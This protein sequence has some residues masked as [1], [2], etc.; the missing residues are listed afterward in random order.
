MRYRTL[1]RTGLEVSEIGLGGAVFA[2]T[3]HGPFDEAN[4]IAAI[5]TALENG[6]NYIDTS[7]H[8]GPSEE[9][10]GR[11]LTGYTGDCII[12]TKIS[13]LQRPTAAETI[14]GVEESLATLRR[15]YV[16]VLLAHDIQHLGEDTDAVEKILHPGG[17]VDGLRQLQREGRVRFIGVSGRLAQ[18]TAAV[19]TGEFDVALSFN[20]FNL[21]DWSAEEALLPQAATHNVGVTMGGVFYQGF[22]SLPLELVLQRVENGLLWTWDWTDTRREFVLN[23][24]EGLREFVGDDLAALRRLAVQFVLSEPRVSAAVIGMKSIAEVTENLA[25]VAAGGLDAE[26]VAKLKEL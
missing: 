3:S 7:R 1:G 21:L 26:T 22:L 16:D 17:M 2:G 11:A 4:A 12:C 5:R 19:Q 20:R 15:S 9:I 14:V 25:A 24:L 13:P 6:V 10:I 18:V 23:R 8:Y